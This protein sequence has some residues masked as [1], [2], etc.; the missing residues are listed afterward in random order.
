[1]TYE[2]EFL[3]N[4]NSLFVGRIDETSQP[5]PDENKA[6]Q[7]GADENKAS[8]TGTDENKASLTGPDGTSAASSKAATVFAQ[9]RGQLFLKPAVMDAAR[10]REIL[11]KP[12]PGQAAVD[13]KLPQMTMEMMGY[14]VAASPAELQVMLNKGPYVE[15]D[16]AWRMLP[17]AVENTLIDA[18]ISVV[19]ARGWDYGAVNGDDLL[20]EVQEHLGEEGEAS[21]PSFKVLQ[22]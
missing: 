21:V 19:T 17:A 14:E 20:R 10:V 2:V 11:H 5:G 1:M 3:E 15:H 16:G 7:N 8:E 22:K 6:P 12:A 18:S 9:C 13:A 4:S